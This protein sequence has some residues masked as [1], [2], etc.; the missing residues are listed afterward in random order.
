MYL[1]INDVAN[2]QFVQVW[3]ARV[4]VT[5]KHSAMAAAPYFI[6]FQVRRRQNFKI[7]RVIEVVTVIRDLVRKIRDLALQRWAI[8]FFACRSWEFVRSFV[9]PHTFP[10]FE[11]Q[12]YT[13]KV[14]I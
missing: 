13:W 12:G 9:L 3:F 11:C 8:V 2:N 14:W 7:K 6:L 5:R 10:H 1:A 4:R